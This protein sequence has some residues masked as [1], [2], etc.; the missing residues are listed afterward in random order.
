MLSVKYHITYW[1]A[2]I[3]AVAIYRLLALSP[4]CVTAFRLIIG[5]LAA[6]TTYASLK[7]HRRGNKKTE[8][9]LYTH[10]A[11]V[12]CL[13]VALG[14]VTDYFQLPKEEIPKPTA[15]LHVL[16]A[17]LT[18]GV[19]ESFRQNVCCAGPPSSPCNIS[20]A[21][22]WMLISDV[23]LS[24]EASALSIRG[25]EPNLIV[26]PGDTYPATWLRS[27]SATRFSLASCSSRTESF[28]KREACPSSMLCHTGVGRTCSTRVVWA[29]PW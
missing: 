28:A 21:N 14:S 10:Q 9:G 3:G 16:S 23:I 11:L 25:R 8:L 29:A 17:F 26:G 7:W 12:A 20:E 18:V 6:Y 19:L 22:C 15:L 27:S 24:L 5:P 2:A 1:A 13:L 4:L